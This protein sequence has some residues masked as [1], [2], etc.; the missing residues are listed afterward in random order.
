MSLPVP[1][2]TMAQAFFHPGRSPD[3]FL[4]VTF[5]NNCLF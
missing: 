3:D 4:P 1:V 5:Q 2:K